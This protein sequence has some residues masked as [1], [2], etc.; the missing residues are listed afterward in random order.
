MKIRF[1]EQ[2]I[3]NKV[4]GVSCCNTAHTSYKLFWA[5][6]NYIIIYYLYSSDLCRLSKIIKIIKKKKKKQCSLT[7]GLNCNRH[8]LTIY[9]TMVKYTM[10]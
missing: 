8:S 5:N 10:I 1:S 4:L 7:E 6:H 2:L 3:F 9:L